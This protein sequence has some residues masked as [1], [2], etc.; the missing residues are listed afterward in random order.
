MG[1]HGSVTGNDKHINI[2]RPAKGRPADFPRAARNILAQGRFEPLR[3]GRNEN[4]AGRHCL[5][6]NRQRRGVGATTRQTHHK[7]LEIHSR[8]ARVKVHM[9]GGQF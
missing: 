5:L 9:A 1:L 6:R 3:R 8:A 2:H 4:P 7:I